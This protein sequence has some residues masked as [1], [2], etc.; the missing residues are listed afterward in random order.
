MLSVYILASP[1]RLE[2]Y[3]EQRPCLIYASTCR[4][5]VKRNNGAQRLST[6]LNVGH[7]SQLGVGTWYSIIISKLPFHIVPLEDSAS[8]GTW[9]GQS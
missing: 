7:Q 1:Q 9:L 2:S 6:P 3:Y 8:A 5:S 4:Y